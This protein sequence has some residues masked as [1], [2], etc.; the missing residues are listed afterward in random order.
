MDDLVD[1]IE[2]FVRTHGP[3][4]N[5][6]QLVVYLEEHTDVEID[7]EWREA[8]DLDWDDYG[9]RWSTSGHGGTT[10][11]SASGPLSLRR[12][13]EDDDSTFKIDD[14]QELR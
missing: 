13:P 1:A 7:A 3:T 11:V 9:R 10:D 4:A 12:P 5:A 14:D 6:C 8:I 2:T